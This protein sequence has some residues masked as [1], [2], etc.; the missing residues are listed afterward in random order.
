V[1]PKRIYFG[2]RD[3]G[4]VWASFI[5]SGIRVVRELSGSTADAGTNQGTSNFN[6]PDLLLL[7]YPV[8]EP[9]TGVLR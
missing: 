5:C 3:A 2:K 9:V 1:L 8:R 6:C 4:K 7:E